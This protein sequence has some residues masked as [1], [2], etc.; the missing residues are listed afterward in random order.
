MT[1]CSSNA[2]ANGVA[3]ASRSL[4]IVAIASSSNDLSAAAGG[5][6]TAPVTKS[7]AISSASYWGTAAAAVPCLRPRVETEWLNVS[8][9]NSRRMWPGPRPYPPPKP[10][11]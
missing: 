7:A 1:R 4:D 10:K 9:M 6:S 3:N 5:Q 2:R 8:S 11:S